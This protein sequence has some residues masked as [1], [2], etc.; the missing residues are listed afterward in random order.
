MCGLG[1]AQED[2]SGTVGVLL[3][4]EPADCGLDGGLNQRG[5]LGGV[6]VEVEVVDVLVLV[7]VV[8]VDVLVV[9]VDVLVEV[10]VLMFV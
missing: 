6:E 7:L 8:L 3:G 9:E 5:E 4:L 2:S 10:E 1:L